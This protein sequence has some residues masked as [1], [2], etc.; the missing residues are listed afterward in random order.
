MSW[1][2]IPLATGFRTNSLQRPLVMSGDD[3]LFSVVFVSLPALE[4]ARGQR[5]GACNH[6]LKVPDLSKI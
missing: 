5:M 3:W 2:G 6:R 4:V 1:S